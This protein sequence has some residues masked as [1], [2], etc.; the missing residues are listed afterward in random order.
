ME[1][2]IIA[3]LPRG[4]RMERRFGVVFDSVP[5]FSDDLTRV[6]GV[7]TREAVILNQLGIYFWGQMAMWRH[8]EMSAIADELQVPV[9]RMI[10]EG[11]TE[12]AKNLCS[13]VAPRQSATLPAS[14]LRTTSVLVVALLGVS[15]GWRS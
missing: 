5:E 8:R 15:V 9:G 3:K 14:P 10:D 13:N 4:H 6:E 1:S 7:L 2:P 12:Q 11:W